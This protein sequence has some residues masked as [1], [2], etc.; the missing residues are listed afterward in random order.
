MLIL[1]SNDDGITSKGIKALVDVAK[2]MGEVVV[3]APNKPQSA[4][5]HAITINGPIWMHQVDFFEGVEA[6]ECSGTPA[7]CVKLAKAVV[8][9]NRKPDLCVSGINHGHN[10]SVSIL[11]SGTMSAAMEASMEGI[12][13]IGFSLDTH[14]LDADFTVAKYWVRK[15]MAHVLENG[16]Q[17]TKLLNVNIPKLPLD[18]IKGLRV[19]R[20]A[21]G[22]WVED[23][24]EYTDPYGKKYFWL[25]GEFDCPD[26]GHDADYSALKEGYVTVVPSMHDLTDY[27][28]VSL[29]RGLEEL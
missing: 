15:I 2:T 12:N 21:E 14:D 23:F 28:G 1:I 10:A 4:Q 9:K 24:K 22:N 29:Q 17:H 3:V 11:Y 26:K 13:S 25:T 8:L 20:Q 18:E 19:C 7:D 6:Y 5:G 16:L 27:K